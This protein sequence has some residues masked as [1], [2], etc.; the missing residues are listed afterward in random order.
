MKALKLL[1]FIVAA[2]L[3]GCGEKSAPEPEHPAASAPAPAPAAEGPAAAPA[4]AAE[5]PAAV[6]AAPAAPSASAPAT[7]S[8]GDLAKGEQVFNANCVSCHGAGVMGAPKL[9]DKAAWEPRIA[10]G[11]DTVYTNALNGVKLM[12]PKGGNASLKD[13]DVKAAVDFMMSKAS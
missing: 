4:P 11:K 7:A 12:P 3:V 9:G 6:P 5:A 2:A 1:P 10:K 8:A 13:E